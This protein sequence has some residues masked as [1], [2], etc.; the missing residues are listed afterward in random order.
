MTPDRNMVN[1]IQLYDKDL[2]IKWNNK[3]QFFELWRK[4]A[5][6]SVL[7]TPITQSIYEEGGKIE[8]APLDERILWW[9]YEADSWA[10]GGPK[11]HSL[12]GDQRWQK[13]QRDR[14]KKQVEDYK[15][16]GK[17]AWHRLNNKFVSTYKKKNSRYPS[18]NSKRVVN[19]WVRPNVK[20][21]TN[22]RV[23]YRTTGN[24]K[25]FDYKKAE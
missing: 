3:R 2:F 9:I 10:H 17:E 7:I 4:Q 20:S 14:R 16:M 13:F 19:K 12:K 25:A 1:K 5:V 11:L 8:F 15:H 18:F 6:G 21:G 24:A 23:M 22:S